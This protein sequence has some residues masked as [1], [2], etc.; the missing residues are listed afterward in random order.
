M[1]NVRRRRGSIRHTILALLVV[2]VII[3][4]AAIVGW[5]TVSSKF[6]PDVNAAKFTAGVNFEPGAQAKIAGTDTTAE[7]TGLQQQVK[8]VDPSDDWKKLFPGSQCSS[9]ANKDSKTGK[10]EVCVADAPQTL[11]IPTGF[12]ATFRNILNS[13]KIAGSIGGIVIMGLLVYV[14]W[15]I[16]NPEDELPSGRSGRRRDYY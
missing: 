1:G 7:L 10:E 15:A 6:S 16:I 9:V 13:Y 11:T 8:G 2:G 4:V 5:T 12:K 3:I 14:V